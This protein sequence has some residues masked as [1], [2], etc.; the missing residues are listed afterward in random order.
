MSSKKRTRTYISNGNIIVC[1]DDEL[2]PVPKRRYGVATIGSIHEHSKQEQQPTPSPAP[3]KRTGVATLSSLQDS[4]SVQNRDS[5]S[6]KF[7]IEKRSSTHPPNPVWYHGQQPSETRAIVTSPYF[8]NLKNEPPLPPL[9]RFPWSAQAVPLPLDAPEEIHVPQPQQRSRGIK[10]D[11][12]ALSKAPMRVLL[13]FGTFEGNGK[14]CWTTA[15][16]CTLHYAKG[17]VIRVRNSNINDY[18]TWDPKKHCYHSTKPGFCIRI[19]KI[20]Q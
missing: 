11:M 15:D 5:G 20:L 19:T 13:Q 16:P 10:I 14:I 1:G 2:T 8:D 9:P 7:A 3:A 18:R 4:P 12:Q 17:D 6:N